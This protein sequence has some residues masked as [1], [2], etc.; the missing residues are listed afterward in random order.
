MGRHVVGVG[1]KFLPGVVPWH[2]ADQEASILADDSSLDW[3]RASDP[4]ALAPVLRRSLEPPRIAGRRERSIY[5]A[6]GEVDG[7]H[8]SVNRVVAL[9]SKPQG[10]QRIEGEIEQACR[11]PKVLQR[12]HQLQASQ[13]TSATVPVETPLARFRDDLFFDLPELSL[14]RKSTVAVDV[15]PD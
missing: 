3:R 8:S 13:T 7:E 10:D 15:P 9:H 5:G 1:L 14:R 2:A 4:G 12:G 11:C 6:V